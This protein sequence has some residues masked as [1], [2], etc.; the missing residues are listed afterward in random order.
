MNHTFQSSMRIPRRVL[1]VFEF[2]SNA[3][4]LERI[5]PPELCFQ[6]VTP[7]PIEMGEGTLIDYRLKL[8]GIPF[9]WRSRI[10]VW[11]PPHRFIDIQERGPYQQWVHTHRFVGQ[12][13]GTRI[14][15]EILYRLPLWPVGEFFYPLIHHQL[16]RI[17]RFR[18]RAIQHHLTSVI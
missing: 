13:D 11:D 5:T 2:F 15:D 14:M 16:S 4:N 9:R 1:D 12:R 3:S 18:N 7:E 17:F 6:I 8:Y 10:T